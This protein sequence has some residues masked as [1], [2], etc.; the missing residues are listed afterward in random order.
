V[1]PL[2][3]QD[4]AQS[5]RAVLSTET[6]PAPLAQTMLAKAQGNPFFV[7]EIAQTLVEQGTLRRQGG[8]TLP[9]T[10]QLPATVQAVLAARIDRLAHH[11]LRGE[12]WDKAVT[13][14]RQAGARAYDRAAFREAV[15][16]FDQALQALEHLPEP[17]DT[18]VLALDLRLALTRPLS[19]LGECERHLALL[20]E[21]EALPLALDDRT[22]LVQVLARMA[23]V[24]RLMGDHVSAIA[25]GQQ[26]LTLSLGEERG[27]KSRAPIAKRPFPRPSTSLAGSKPHRSSC[28]R[29]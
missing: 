8:I 29:R 3:P 18:R 28:G 4:S 12:V 10:L 17:G 1:S 14:C 5:V 9:P 2:S 15:A 19:T 7:E 25:A 20:G 27:G 26:A 23:H 24:H 6:V 11:A 13:Y 22:R 16:S 21:A